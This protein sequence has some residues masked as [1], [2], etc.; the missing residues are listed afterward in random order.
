VVH[1]SSDTAYEGC[2]AGN[3][4]AGAI[5]ST[6]H[7]INATTW[8]LHGAALRDTELQNRLVLE[9]KKGERKEAL[10]V[11]PL[12]A[13]PGPLYGA[14]QSRSVCQHSDSHCNVENLSE[15]GSI[16]TRILRDGNG[17]KKMDSLTAVRRFHNDL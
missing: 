1:F 17:P 12:G 5:R 2:D 9:G 14:G 10:V 4:I 7:C 16:K 6:R 8:T 11:Q 15:Q 3:W 13:A